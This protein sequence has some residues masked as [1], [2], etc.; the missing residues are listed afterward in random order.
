[1]RSN[2]TSVP[3]KEYI[4]NINNNVKQKKCPKKDRERML[5]HAYTLH[6]L[7]YTN[8]DLCRSYICTGE[9]D[10]K[11]ILEHDL[12]EKLLCNKKMIYLA[13]RAE[14]RNIIFDTNTNA[15]K[16]YMNNVL[17]ENDA[18]RKMN[19]ETLLKNN[20]NYKELLHTHTVDDAQHI[21]LTQYVNNNYSK[22]ELAH[23]FIND[24]LT[25]SFD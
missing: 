8:D 15:Y 9:P 18:L 21:A 2:R 25:V 22:S 23:E 16:D 10:I 1:M 12:H 3:H 19:I 11:T 7:E 5:R 4:N 13:S 20:T 24:K 14:K 17:D 6:K